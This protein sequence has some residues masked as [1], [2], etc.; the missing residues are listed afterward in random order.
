MPS[1][2]SP[3]IYPRE[4]DFSFYV[5]QISTSACAMVGIAERGPIN[6]PTLVTSW[7]QFLTAFGGY[8]AAGYL[9]YAARAFCR[10]CPPG[11][12]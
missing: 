11:G 6:E 7:E 3:G 5:K 4:I 12:G 1:Y 8:L 2:L 10:Q 9:A